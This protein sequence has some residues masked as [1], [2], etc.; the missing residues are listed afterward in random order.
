MTVK[1]RLALQ[2]KQTQM[3]TRSLMKSTTCM[4]DQA[5]TKT[6]AVM[7]HLCNFSVLFGL[8]VLSAVMCSD[9]L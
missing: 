2:T 3:N 7:V 8:T 6:Y 4:S 5:F 9:I 1:L